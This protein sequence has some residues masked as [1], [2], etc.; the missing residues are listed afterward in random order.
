MSCGIPT[1]SCQLSGKSL[2]WFNMWCLPMDT[3]VDPYRI[4]RKIRGL[5]FMCVRQIYGR[6]PQINSQI[7][8]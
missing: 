7:Y 8:P 4:L 3:S 2:D 1:N 6:T 5:K